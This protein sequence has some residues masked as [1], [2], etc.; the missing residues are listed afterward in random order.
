MAKLEDRLDHLLG[1]AAAELL[2]KDFELRTVGD[3]LRHYPRQYVTMGQLMSPEDLEPGIHVT[4]VARVLSAKL[5]PMRRNPKLK[6]LKL[7]LNDGRNEYDVTFFNGHKISYHIK[8]GMRGMFSGVLGKFH[9]HLQLTH[10]GYLMMPDAVAGGDAQL[11]R[12][13]DKIR[14]GGAIADMARGLVTDDGLAVSDLAQP[15]LPMY[16]AS[17]DTESWAIMRCVR[18]VL[19]L[20]DEIE[21]PLPEPVRA[22][23]Q[24][25]SLDR[26]LR[27]MHFP[28]T[29]EEA[30]LAL[31]RLRF[32]EAAA[33]QLLLAQRRLEGTKAGAPPCPRV[34]GGIRAA[35]EERLPFELTAGQLA[36]GATL[37][38]ELA[39]PHPMNR[40]L[41][42]EVGSG[43]TIVAILAMLQVIDSGH[44]TAVLAPTE[45]LAAQHARSIREMLF[46]LATAGE[47]GA[48]EMA[49][50]VTLLTGSLTAAQ[51]KVALAEIASGE[52]GI[53]V[54]THALFQ[55]GVE[56]ADLG[57]VVI[58][59][60]HRFGVD[61]RDLMRSKAK[62]GVS[63]H[64]LVM[65]AT[66]IP[67][68]IAM[69]VFGDLEVSTLRELPRGRSPIKTSVVPAQQR[70]GWVDRA[71]ERIVEEVGDGRQAYV[72][73]PRIGDEKS[74][75]PPTPPVMALDLPEPDS[76]DKKGPDEQEMVAAVEL[77]DKL[78]A[79]GLS[80]IRVGLL[81]GRQ[82]PNEK[83][84]VMQEFGAGMIDALVC[85]TVVEVGVDVPNA[86]VMVIMDAERFGISQLHQLRGRI[87]RGGHQ[88]LCI[89]VTNR[90]P[91]GKAWERLTAVAATNDGFALANLDLEHRHEGDVVGAAQSGRRSG[92]L[93]SLLK[94]EQVIADAKEFATA[95]IARD[96]SLREHPG[97]AEMARSVAATTS[98]EY[99]HKA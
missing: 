72:V 9:G 94:D 40:L 27:T 15:M 87:G 59:E 61:Q 90:N 98:T 39:R 22:Q 1:N 7:R 73:C 41:Q 89:F 10:P 97:L 3:V 92:L 11:L 51:K 53:V 62:G 18:Q 26:A 75:P 35:F 42:G 77:F 70:P 6:M 14:G 47:L 88:G 36:V 30:A 79:G 28:R 38:E 58:D 23:H 50:R 46:E 16:R 34:A 57:L 81:H 96:P 65:T 13:G 74:D 95:I 2:L 71:W 31:E 83:N 49:T 69:T 78:I 32:D 64:V 85:T 24:L 91:G 20:L 82:P 67:R 12:T 21:D 55:R 66:P 52:A 29:K 19:D 17:K 8:E 86:T 76:P 60:Q 93:L 4:I 54:G 37:E 45:V 99:L 5:L 56:F 48:P 43:K 80:S 63:P 25:I 68:T 84:T 33:L 44:Q